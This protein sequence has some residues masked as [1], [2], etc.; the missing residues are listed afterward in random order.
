MG[1]PLRV[2]SEDMWGL[3][4]GLLSEPMGTH[5]L[6]SSSFLWLILGIL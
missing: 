4:K 5:R 2:A 1:I 6:L 3:L